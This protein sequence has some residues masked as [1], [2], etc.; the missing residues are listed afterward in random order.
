MLLLYGVYVQNNSANY[1][2]VIQAGLLEIAQVT[3]TLHKLAIAFLNENRY[4][5]IH[6][7]NI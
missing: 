1:A 7:Y 5:I 6:I 4:H 3:Q 2:I